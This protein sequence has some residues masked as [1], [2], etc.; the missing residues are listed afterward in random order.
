[1]LLVTGVLWTLSVD[2][3][4]FAQTHTVWTLRKEAIVLSGML[5]Y[6]LMAWLML[7]A[8][9]PAWLER[10]L[11]GLD[12]LYR[13]HKHA[14]IAAALLF[15]AHWLIKLVPKWLAG[16]GWIAAKPRGGGGGGQAA[17]L[18]A[19]LHGPAK[20]LGEWAIY[21]MLALVAI[22]LLKRIPYHWFRK[23]HRLFALAFLVITF[24]GLVLLPAAM[25]PTPF[26][27][28]LALCALAG[29]VAALR[30]LAGRIGLKR[31]HQGTIAAV[32]RLGDD[33]VA[34]CCNVDAMPHRPGQFAYLRIGNGEPHPFTIVSAGLDP[35]EV[36]FAIKALGDDTR[37]MQ[38][39]RP[40]QPVVVEG[41][42]G[43]FDFADEGHGQVWVATGI[44]ITPFLSRLEWL[45]ANGG[46]RQAVSLFYCGGEPGRD[47]F[48]E[49]LVALCR[50]AGVSLHWIQ[51]GSDGPLTLAKI[52]A[53]NRHASQST[54]W[55][56]G[57]QALGDTLAR[58]WHALGL[59]E[60]RFRRELFA[61]R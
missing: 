16:W 5:S 34:L 28:L 49:R 18:V 57:A 52:L 29:S 30:S 31:R 26:G 23:V 55:Y 15:A 33:I 47:P 27:A 8:N 44:G 48:A 61:M 41:P 21:A 9:R 53:D 42:Y 1:M 54:L 60:R 39:L 58:S 43:R 19:Q 25:W 11:G 36:R 35:R 17:D 7:L 56:C 14:G 59:P 37:G 12:K 20:H 22:A 38:A 40:G 2:P 6:V 4:W 3:A 13:M 10:R 50:Q 32:E 51:R 24:H 46:S 45:A